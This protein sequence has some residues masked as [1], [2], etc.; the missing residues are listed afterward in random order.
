MTSS[1]MTE[2]AGYEAAARML[3]GQDAPTA[4]LASSLI[5][6]MG[7]RRAAEDAGLKLGRDLSVVT[8]D[9]ELSYMHNGTDVPIYTATRSSVREAG[10]LTAQMLLDRIAEPMGAERHTLLEATLV[11]GQSTAI[12]R[13]HV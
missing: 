6:A 4:F 2:A 12:G 9:D 13:A 7:V 3:A 1:E 5:T 10:R 11:V 8:H